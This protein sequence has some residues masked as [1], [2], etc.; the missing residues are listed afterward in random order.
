MYRSFPWFRQCEDSKG[1]V[2]IHF[3]PL[4][5]ITEEECK[6]AAIRMPQRSSGSSLSSSPSGVSASASRPLPIAEVASPAR[7]LLVSSA[8]AAS[9]SSVASPGH[10]S[11][12]GMGS[13]SSEADRG[14]CVSS[15]AS[16]SRMSASASG[17]SPNAAPASP[18]HV[19]AM[20]S[21]DA[22]SESSLASQVNG[23][24]GGAGASSPDAERDSAGTSTCR[25]PSNPG[26]SPRF[27]LHVDVRVCKHIRTCVSAQEVGFAWHSNLQDGQPDRWVVDFLV[28]VLI[29]EAPSIHARTVLTLARGPRAVV[30]AQHY[31]FVCRRATHTLLRTGPAS[32]RN[33][34]FSILL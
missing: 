32:P 26:A 17:P 31:V 28:H 7:S 10:A 19:L 14:S 11:I 5:D 6:G 24:P 22:A 33:W 25:S 4:P 34:R 30:I 9:A 18:G 27:G 8:A 12:P 13:P 23:S 2:A 21:P 16:P 20:S 3:E 15:A 1:A 29:L